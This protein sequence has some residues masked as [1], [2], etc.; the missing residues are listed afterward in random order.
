MAG[1]LSGTVLTAVLLWRLAKAVER[2]RRGRVDLRN[3]I[4]GVR[5]QLEV[6]RNNFMTM[7]GVGLWTLVG[8]GAVVFVLVQM[9]KGR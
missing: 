2:Y 9:V 6:V 3:Y 7:V 4:N 8:A 5:G 1:Y